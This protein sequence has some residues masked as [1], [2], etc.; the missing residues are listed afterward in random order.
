MWNTINFEQVYWRV[1]FCFLINLF[2]LYRSW[3]RTIVWY[4]LDLFPHFLLDLMK[5]SLK[6]SEDILLNKWKYLNCGTYLYLGIY[7]KKYL[8]CS[9]ENT[10]S[11]VYSFF[12]GHD[13]FFYKMSIIFS[14]MNH[15]LLN[16]MVVLVCRGKDYLNKRQNFHMHS[17]DVLCSDRNHEENSQLFKLNH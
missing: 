5:L 4:A 6:W 17:I 8:F 3:K 15:S 10:K 16:S 9:K 1:R 14:L 7:I 11:F 13:W 12:G 2:N